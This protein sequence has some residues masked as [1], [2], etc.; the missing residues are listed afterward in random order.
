MPVITYIQTPKK[1]PIHQSIFQYP[2][3]WPIH[4]SKIS[5]TVVSIRTLLKQ[6]PEEISNQSSIRK[7]YCI[8][9]TSHKIFCIAMAAWHHINPTKGNTLLKKAC[10]DSG[11][12]PEVF[13][14]EVNNS[15]A[16]CLS[17]PSTIL[18]PSH[19]ANKTMSINHAKSLDI[20]N[21]FWSLKTNSQRI[22][23]PEHS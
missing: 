13:H 19:S 1:S 21:W 22:R 20:F 12:L 15:V 9:L 6:N 23:K 16:W 10:A 8:N 11:Q 7:S 18:K 17:K 2:P 3:A 14:L 5:V 4:T